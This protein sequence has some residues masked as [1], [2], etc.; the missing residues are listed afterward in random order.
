MSK[1]TVLAVFALGSVLTALL[2]LLAF[3]SPAAG[4]PDTLVLGGGRVAKVRL[5]GGAGLSS[6]AIIGGMGGVAALLVALLG[7]ISRRPAPALVRALHPDARGQ[8]LTEFALVF[9]VL[10]VTMLAISQMALMYN[11]KNVVLY[12]S[13]AAARSAAVWIP[14]ETDDEWPGEINQSIF[15]S[16]KM[17]N[18]QLAAAYANV[19]I[20]QRASWIL[21][22]L[23]S[24]G[25]GLE[26]IV[27][28]VDA[29][30]SYIPGLSELFDYADRFAYAYAMTYVWLGQT[31]NNATDFSAAGWPFE[32]LTFDDPNGDISV[33]IVHQFYLVVPLV[34]EFLGE[35][36]DTP[37]EFF[38]LDFLGSDDH[39]TTLRATCTLTLEGREELF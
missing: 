17:R 2:V 22:D 28:F 18:I 36:T 7:T 34:N 35:I 1:R 31:T 23:G 33:Q 25:A 20:S 19:P 39:F 32:D 4:L 30:L 37:I 8:A 6:L 29:I 15:L 3:P 5:E 21:A 26:E 10:L 9:P 27:V 38:W 24:F 11:A 13:Y 12:S 16:E 14:A